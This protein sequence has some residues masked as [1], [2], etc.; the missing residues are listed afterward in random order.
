MQRCEHT[1]GRN[2]GSS[3]TEE[4]GRRKRAAGPFLRGSSLQYKMILI[5]ENKLHSYLPAPK[6]KPNPLKVQFEEIQKQNL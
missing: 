6:T 1:N 4:A 3:D 2:S 5:Q